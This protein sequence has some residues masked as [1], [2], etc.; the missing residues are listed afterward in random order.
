[1]I[2]IKSSLSNYDK[3]EEPTPPPAQDL[4]TYAS[5]Y[6][7]GFSKQVGGG[8][9]TAYG[10][11]NPIPDWTQS[12]WEIY[13]FKVGNNR[14]IINLGSGAYGACVAF[15]CS[16]F[17]Q[18]LHITHNGF[19]LNIGTYYFTFR[20]CGDELNLTTVAE[21]M[22]FE[23]SINGGSTYITHYNTGIP[24]KTSN[25]L[26]ANTLHTTPNIVINS[27]LSVFRIRFSNIGNFGV[28]KQT[29]MTCIDDIQI[30]QV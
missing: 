19:P 14:N 27:N 15:F 5:L 28:R 22:S 18:F 29:I 24:F 16:S 3:Y 17:H 6:N 13:Y 21:P 26:H 8:L 2:S 4:L 12:G 10:S 9:S 23:Y 11:T 20:C 30:F 25:M 1:M 7:L